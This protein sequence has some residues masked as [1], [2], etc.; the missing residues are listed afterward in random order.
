M[1]LGFLTVPFG[2][3][4]LE[5]V[6]GW[7]KENG[8]GALEVACWPAGSGDA[9][10]YAGVTHI[11]VDSLDEAGATQIQDMLG[12][13]G[14]EISGL[15]YYPNNLH[16]DP[17]HREAVNEHTRKVIRAAALLEAPVVNTFVGRDKTRSH[18]E[19]M[20]EFRRVWP[21]L[22]AEAESANVK[23]GIENCP[24]LFS[25]DEWPGGNNLAYSP[26][27]WRE[28]FDE[29]PSASFGLNFDPSHL[30]WQM[31]DVERAIYEFADR[32]VHV[33]A[34][35]LE[36]RPDG[37]Y[38]HGVMSLGMGWQ[39]PRLPGLGDVRWDR[40]FAALYASGYDGPVII[41]HED[42]KFEGTEE[43]IIRG[44]HLARDVLRPYIV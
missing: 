24:M 26:A 32:L 40:F 44:F 28:M 38:E 19:N 22:V 17:G 35:D 42:R 8:F 10:R 18:P 11:D 30:I 23:I 3:W 16:P 29:I 37:L 13:L 4:S 2:D 6:A 21:D 36:V 43:L 27:I 1:K 12:K 33:H 14:I 20:A 39:V 15:G 9:R 7:A 5:Q 34:K 25:L 31:I 41:E